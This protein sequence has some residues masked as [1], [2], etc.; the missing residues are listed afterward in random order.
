MK[1]RQIV[2]RCW[3]VLVFMS[4][5]SGCA[6]TAEQKAEFDAATLVRVDPALFKVEPVTP[7]TRL[8]MRLALLV[9][10]SV[11]GDWTV[12]P[13]L[14]G[15]WMTGKKDVE[16]PL[17]RRMQ[18]EAIIETALRKA[19][20]ATVQG[21]VKTVSSVPVQGENFDATLELVSARFDYDERRLTWFPVPIPFA[22]GLEVGQFEA[23]ARLSMQLRLVDAQGQPVWSRDYDDGPRTSVWDYPWNPDWRAGIQ[24]VAHEAAWRLA[25]QVLQD[26]RDYQATQRIK[27]RTL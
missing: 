26:L 11:P 8:P 6:L 20:E 7:E 2:G 9:P 23:S 17:S 4:L 16:V 25:Q 1:S 24:R 22:L 21:E 10:P 27:P 19:L 12:L 3:T 15:A 5:L 13:Y 18:T 14:P